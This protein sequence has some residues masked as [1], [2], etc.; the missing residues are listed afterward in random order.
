MYT[1]INGFENKK[2]ES[3]SNIRNIHFNKF[4][5]LFGNLGTFKTETQY[6]CGNIFGS[7]YD[8]E[9]GV[10]I[11]QTNYD[12]KKALRIY[13]DYADYRFTRHTDEKLVSELQKR[14]AKVKLTEFP[15]G[16]VTVENYVIGQEIPFYDNC[17]TLYDVI[18]NNKSIKPTQLYLEVLKILKELAQNEIIYS[19]VHARNFLVDTVDTTVKLI[20]FDEHL[21]LFNGN[22]DCMIDNLK[23][24]LY[25]L[26]SINNIEF[27]EDFEKTETL[28]EIE[29]CVYEKHIKL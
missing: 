10:Y 16:I 21:I 5:D 11:Y 20:D 25:K 27:K 7:D 28:S 12:V 19:D 6:D 29:E 14:Q 4:S 1:I 26:N 2:G 17:N 8:V 9:N 22:K 18:L 15:T 23:T 3:Y 13:K 24:M